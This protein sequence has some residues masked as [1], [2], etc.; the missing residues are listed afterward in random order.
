MSILR[1]LAAALLLLPSFAAG[2][3]L[4]STVST[5][6]A[7]VVTLQFADGEPFAYESFEVIAEGGSV[8]VQ[9]GR[10]D[11]LGRA[12]I[13]PVEGRRLQFRATSRDGHGVTLMLAPQVSTV[14]TEP[15]PGVPRWLLVLCGAGLLF[16]LFG[17]FQLFSRRR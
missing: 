1:M 13:L 14:G 11:A 2:H 8:P 10:T 4:N 6:T 7:S 17:V 5:Q 16:G 12:A 3:E 9:T 15:A